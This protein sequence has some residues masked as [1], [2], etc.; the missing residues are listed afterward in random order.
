MSS[1]VLATISLTKYFMSSVLLIH[2][3]VHVWKSEDPLE[4]PTATCAA[5]IPYFN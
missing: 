3:C 4:L 1:E 5:D 2:T